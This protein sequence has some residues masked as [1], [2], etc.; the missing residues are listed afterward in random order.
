M[1]YSRMFIMLLLNTDD[2]L[3]YMVI[4]FAEAEVKI[5]SFYVFFP[6]IYLLVIFI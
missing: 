5:D 3:S 4:L 2:V 6:V 1:S